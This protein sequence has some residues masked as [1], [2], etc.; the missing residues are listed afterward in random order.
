M[1]YLDILIGFSLIMLVFSS[2]VSVVQTLL[3]RTLAIKGR[4]LARTLLEELERAWGESTPLKQSGVDAWMQVALELERSLK[5]R[6]GILG[7][8]LRNVKVE[9][10]AGILKL[11]LAEGARWVPPGLRA[12]WDAAVRRLAVRWGGYVARLKHSYEG[13]TRRWVVGVALAAALA[14]NVDAVRIVRV[15]SVAKETR[16]ALEAVALKLDHGTWEKVPANLSEWQRHNLAELAATGLPLGWEK[17]PLWVCH[18]E[19]RL[20]RT[21]NERCGTGVEIVPTIWLWLVRLLGLL[22]GAGL[23]AQGAPFWYSALDTV[24]GLKK[25]D[26]KEPA[27]P[28]AEAAELVAMVGQGRDRA[29]A[30]GEAAPGS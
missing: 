26:A 13:H 2:A 23:I 30:G 25:K 3:K 28:A 15:L 21:W 6:K 9:D 12:E 19:E 16:A 7:G 27:V 5:S 17:A 11:V 18:G 4:A 20:G 1:I 29:A 14:F 22:V 24:L 8:S 10:G